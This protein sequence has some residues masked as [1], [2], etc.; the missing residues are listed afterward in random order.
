MDATTSIKSGGLYSSSNATTTTKSGGVYSRWNT[1]TI[2]YLV[3]LLFSLTSG[4]LFF[5]NATSS[6]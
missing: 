1:T 6:I 5:L 2:L 4:S 3:G